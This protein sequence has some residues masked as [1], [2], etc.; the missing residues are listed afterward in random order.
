MGIGAP[1]DITDCR[2]FFAEPATARQRQYE[3]LRAFFLDGL[4]SKEVAHRFGYSHGAFRVLCH[5]FRR[6]LLRDFLRHDT[7]WSA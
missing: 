7:A 1:I 6:G 4:T 2:R 5:D 3:A